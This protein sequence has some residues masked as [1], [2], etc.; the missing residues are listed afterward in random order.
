MQGAG[1]LD[2]AGMKPS[3]CGGF[4][5]FRVLGFWGRV[6]GLGVRGHSSTG[7]LLEFQGFVWEGD[8]IVSGVRG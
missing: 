8:C 4:I 6:P 2:V 1:G 5:G 7:Q 3:G